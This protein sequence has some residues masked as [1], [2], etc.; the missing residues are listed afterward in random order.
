MKTYLFSGGRLKV[1]DMPQVV[2][3]VKRIFHS[4]KITEQNYISRWI[5]SKREI[6][7][8]YS[9]NSQQIEETMAC[10]FID[11]EGNRYFV[12]TFRG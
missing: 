9:V 11:K 10:D 5:I 7:K 3:H 8:D 12:E 6:P 1:E 2:T 4:I